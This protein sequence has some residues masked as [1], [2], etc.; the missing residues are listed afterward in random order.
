MSDSIESHLKEDRRFPP[1]A[2]FAKK[3]RVPS[4]AEYTAMYDLSLDEPE[5]FWREQTQRP[6][7]PHAVDR[8]S[9]SGSCPHAKWFVGA[10]LNVTESCLDRHLDDRRAHTRRDR[11][12]GRA[13]R[14]PHAHLRRAAPRGRAPRRRARATSA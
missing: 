11:L 14:H 12:G 2:E 8:R 1:S 6:R 10:T 4:H 13:R 7:L 3:A 9:P 5:T